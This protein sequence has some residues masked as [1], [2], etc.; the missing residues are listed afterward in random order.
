MLSTTRLIELGAAKLNVSR[1]MRARGHALPPLEAELVA[2]DADPTRVVAEYAS[3]AL[4]LGC[5]LCEALG[6]TY[7]VPAAPASGAWPQGQPPDVTTV[8]FLDENWDDAKRRIKAASTDQLKQALDAAR[9]APR[10]PGQVPNVVVVAPTA[11]TS[12]ARREILNIGAVLEGG[13]AARA[14]GGDGARVRVMLARELVL[15]L[16]EHVGVPTHTRLSAE[17]ARRFVA[18]CRVHPSQLAILPTSD[19]V[20]VFYDY[21]EGDIVRVTRPTSV[22]FRIVSRDLT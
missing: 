10:P 20:A 22:E 14:L 4:E 6:G 11:L 17:A 19:P 18:Q 13:S 5:S 8:V 16:A 12:D 21:C 7:A 3:R 2:D 9:L 15:P 1:M